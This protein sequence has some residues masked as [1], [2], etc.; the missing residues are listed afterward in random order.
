MV[1]L[2]SLQSHAKAFVAFMTCINSPMLT[3]AAAVK[4]AVALLRKTGT[5]EHLATGVQLSLAGAAL[6]PALLIMEIPTITSVVRQGS[7]YSVRD[8]QEP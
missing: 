4:I 5:P 2:E 8:K 6:M 3:K 7:Q 1:Q